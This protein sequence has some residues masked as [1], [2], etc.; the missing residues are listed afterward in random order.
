MTVVCSLYKILVRKF[1]CM[2]F[3]CTYKW[4]NDID[5]S[6]LCARVEC[7]LQ[8]RCSM[9]I[10]VQSSRNFFFTLVFSYSAR[11]FILGRNWVGSRFLNNLVLLD[12]S[13]GSFP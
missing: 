12:R 9:N 3:L 8:M 10:H 6:H 2:P 13:C 7:I 5:L 4:A 1:N 11:V